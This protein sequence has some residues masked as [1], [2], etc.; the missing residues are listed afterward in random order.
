[1]GALEAGMEAYG[2][3]DPRSSAA[4]AG[5]IEEADEAEL[6]RLLEV[7]ELSKKLPNINP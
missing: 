6:L 3:E 2:E 5:A 4:A 7:Q 1:M